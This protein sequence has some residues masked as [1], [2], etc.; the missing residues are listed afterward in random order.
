MWGSNEGAF[1]EAWEEGK[2]RFK[3]IIDKFIEEYKLDKE[4]SKNDCT[5]DSNKV[6]FSKNI[7]IIHG[8]DEA[9]KETVARVVD[10]IGLNPI[11]LHE[12][13]DKGRTIIEKFEYFADNVGY[14]IALLSPDDLCIEDNVEKRRARQNVVFELGYFT[15]LLGRDRTF[16][17]VSGN[18]NIE[19]MS[20]YQGVIYKKYDSEGAWKIKLIKELKAVGYKVSADS[21]L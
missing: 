15:G 4:L 13:E 12:Q 20:D 11:I 10:K 6:E 8:H 5:L 14:A 17:L 9:M 2:I 18:E 1:R 21:I 16:A 7:F 19:L 3:N